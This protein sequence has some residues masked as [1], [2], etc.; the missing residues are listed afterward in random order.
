ML[1]RFRVAQ[2]GRLILLL[3]VIASGV[4]FISPVRAQDKTQIELRQFDLLTASSGWV[5]LDQ[6]IFWT[7]DVGQT[8]DDISPSL[9]S[10]AVIQDVQFKDSELGWVLFT[11]LNPQGGALFHLANTT[12]SG[13]TWMTRALSLFE[14]GEIASYAEKTE[15]GWFD[16]QRGWI[17]VKQTG[18]SNFSIG[19][20]FTTSDGGGTWSRSALPI[21]DTIYFSNPSSGWA[22]GGPTGD[23]VFITQNTGVTW[24]NVSPENAIEN[25]RS[26][27]YAPFVSSAGSL[28]VTTNVG[29]INSLNVYRFEASSSKWSFFDQVP[30]NVEPGLIG[31]SILDVQNFVATIPGTKTIVRMRDGQLDLIENQDGF[32]DSIVALDM[33]SLDVG[34][35]KSVESNCSTIS[36]LT[37][38]S[39]S[40]SCSSTTRLLGTA[41]G[42]VTWQ[43]VALPLPQSGTTRVTTLSTS[44]V[45]T[46]NSLSN[47]ENSQI[48]IGQGFDA[49]EI[50]TLSQMQTWSANSPF[51]AV[52]LYIGGS[53]RACDNLALTSTYLKQLSQQG[54]KFIPT[55]VGPQAPCTGYLTK[56]SS[57]PTTA[58]NQGVAQADLAVERL[59]EL[60]LTY[61]DK[62]GSVI[63]YDIEYYGTNAACRTA[64]NS[65]M[66]GWVS[67]IH[68]RGNLAGV[69]SSPSCN[70]GLSDFRTIT[71]VPDVVWIAA[72][73]YS[74]GHP[75]AH[76][77]PTAS[78]WDW[79]GTCMPGTA[80]PT[81]Q[82][83]RQYSGDH[84]ETWGNLTLEIDN[85][86]LDGVV[87]IPFIS[88]PPLYITPTPIPSRQR[89]VLKSQALTP[90]SLITQ[91]GT[92]SGSLPSL[93]LPDQSGAQDNPAAYV[94]FQT[95]NTVY[96]GYQSFYLPGD[97]Q[98]NSISTMLLQVNFKGPLS[99]TQNWTWSI[100]DWNKS[101]WIKL[102]DSIAATPNQWNTLLLK[103]PNPHRYLSPG[104]EIRIQ[105]KSNNANNDAKIDYEA[106]HITYFS[107]PATPTPV[108]PIIT[109]K[110]PGIFSAQT[111]TP[112]P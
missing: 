65:F 103:I 84:N 87:A 34:W 46:M 58:Y 18:G 15:M 77:D 51:K 49:C 11:T 72:W 101:L 19:A 104:R 55:W 70:T 44:R 94:S 2:F 92:T 68:T 85:D 66:N 75:D 42:G 97:A 25:I 7:S 81:H 63:Y 86:V 45:T 47:L 83:L 27:V 8:W 93:S 110:R 96:S 88:N 5:L 26:T 36:S 61:P 56:M 107:T 91:Y 37:D 100:Y 109:P 69:Y 23:Q 74:L 106:I 43:S 14:S 16:A 53:S 112:E 41:D 71:N 39:A 54:W 108:V 90:A 22:V 31:L 59:S 35:A 67:Q 13:I 111:S 21:A 24:Q 28:L 57:D 3:S 78:V 38:S 89:P 73:Y 98:S 12:N 29:A 105:L 33:I 52:N 20:L 17:S 30:L 82:R 40:V 60:G 76:Y 48:L 80:W 6:K 1:F 4:G 9:P 50:P 64:V 32:S 102:G 79:L 95:P 10:G 62:T 99:S